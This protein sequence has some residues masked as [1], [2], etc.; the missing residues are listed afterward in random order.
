M[1]QTILTSLFTLGDVQ[2]GLIAGFLFMLPLRKRAGFAWRFPVGAAAALLLAVLSFRFHGY[3]TSR[4]LDWIRSFPSPPLFWGACFHSLFAC[5]SQLLLLTA[6]FFF[7]CDLPPVQQ[8]YG[9]A[10]SLLSENLAYVLYLSVYPQAGHRVM[11]SRME[12]PWIELMIL[13]VTF[14]CLY[15]FVARRLPQDKEY[16]FRCG[17]RSAVLVLILLL[18]RTLGVYARVSRMKPEFFRAYLVVSAVLYALLLVSQLMLRRIHDWRNVAALESQLRENQR[19]EHQR[20]LESTDTLKHV[21]HELKHILAAIP[22][23]DNRHAGFVRE[24]E[25]ALTTYEAHM[26]TGNDTLDALLSIA[27]KRCRE[28]DVQWTCVAD[29]SALQ[30]VNPMDLYILLGNALDNAL[31]SASQADDPD[32]RF[33]SLNIRQ[34]RGMAYIRLENFCPTEPMFADGLPVTNKPDPDRH[35]YGVRSIRD[36]VA[37]YGGEVS[38]T[39]HA[40]VFTLD[41]ALPMKTE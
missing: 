15:L 26:D 10:C 13:A 8:I 24:L 40:Q 22:I 14:A 1:M 30:M 36:I 17:P 33:L 34:Q 9:A 37:R 5:T 41:I 11:N 23:E 31:E 7:C 21:G 35:G 28:N 20:F 32:K 3:A 18:A 25:E 12:H 38:M 27:W 16:R 6:V 4:L 2:C 39:A 29:G 19:Q